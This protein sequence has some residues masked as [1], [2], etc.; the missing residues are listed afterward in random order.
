M[1]IFI[2]ILLSVSFNSIAQ[3]YSKKQL[4]QMS[5]DRLFPKDASTKVN[6]DMSDI[7]V[8]WNKVFDVQNLKR[9]HY[10][11]RSDWSKVFPITE[12]RIHKIEGKR[13]YHGLVPLKYR[14]DVIEN[15]ETNRLIANLKI[16][17][18]PSKTYLRRMKKYA[19]TGHEDEKHYPGLEI[20]NQQIKENLAESELRW[21]KQAPE[22][23]SFKFEFV[24]TP[25]EAH[26]SIKVVTYFG[27]I[28]NSFIMAPAPSSVLTHEIGHMLGLDEE[29]AYFMTN[30]L[31]VHTL[32]DQ[33]NKHTEYLTYKESRCNLDSIMCWREKIYD[34]HLNH[35]FGRIH[36]K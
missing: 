28:Y 9:D 36:L 2:L 11:H 31:P 35:I 25:A 30:I 16:H 6:A 13:T 23:I 20:L 24:N 27:A 33:S 7:V 22:N 34:Y 1:K 15:P 21:N 5:L 3:N 18:Y 19:S 10:K 4:I 17:F 12:K 14:Y 8:E 26:Y 32:L 29:Y